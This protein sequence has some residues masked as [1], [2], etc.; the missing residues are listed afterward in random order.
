MGITIKKASS[1]NSKYSIPE[2]AALTPGA[3]VHIGD[4]ERG[5]ESAEGKGPRGALNRRG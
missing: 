1:N 4:M 3:V 5:Q 2:D